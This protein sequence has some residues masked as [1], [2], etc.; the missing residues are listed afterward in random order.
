MAN[1]FVKLSSPT[2]K[3]DYSQNEL[4]ISD[5]NESSQ[6][7]SSLAPQG[8]MRSRSASFMKKAPI[9][10]SQQPST[11]DTPEESVEAEAP[12]KGTVKNMLNSFFF[13]RTVRNCYEARSYFD[14]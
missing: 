7:K 3:G 8:G 2:K 5:A 4:I 13:K 6:P 1:L 11:L 14:R 10:H 12:N 9:N